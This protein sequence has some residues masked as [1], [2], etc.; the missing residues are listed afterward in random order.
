M[1]YDSKLGRLDGDDGKPTTVSGEELGV[2][3]KFVFILISLSI[4]C[5]LSVIS[6]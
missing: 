4:S 2:N 3:D 5:D 1:S 6:I